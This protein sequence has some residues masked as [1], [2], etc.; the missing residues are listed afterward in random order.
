M[1]RET[2]DRPWF[3]YILRTRT[4]ALYTGISTDPLRRL[5]E[6][7]GSKRGARSLRGKGPLMLVW[8]CCAGDRSAASRLEARLKRL[9]KPDKERIVKG[10]LEAEL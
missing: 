2:A 7:G 4:G 9:G 5:A 6:H 1:H 3:V 8:Q 10:E